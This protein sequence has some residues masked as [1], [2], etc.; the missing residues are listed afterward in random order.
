LRKALEDAREQGR[1]EL[2]EKPEFVLAVGVL[3]GIAVTVGGVYL[4]G[5]LRPTIPAAS[6]P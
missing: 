6:A 3:V 1:R 5:V 4:L 2:W